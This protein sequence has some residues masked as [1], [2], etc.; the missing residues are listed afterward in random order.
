M[1]SEFSNLKDSVLFLVYSSLP[2]AKCKVDV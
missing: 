2:N 1:T